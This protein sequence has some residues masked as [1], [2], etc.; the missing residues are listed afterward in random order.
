MGSR[1]RLLADMIDLTWPMNTGT[2]LEYAVVITGTEQG[3]AE[4]PPG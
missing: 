3:A 4:A 1:R 2:V